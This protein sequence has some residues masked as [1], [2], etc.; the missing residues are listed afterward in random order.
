MTAPAR[1]NAADFCM[2]LA[3]APHDEWPALI[4]GDPRRQR[5]ARQMLAVLAAAPPVTP[6]QRAAVRAVFKGKTS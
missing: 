3:C 2:T 1:F 5:I 6:E 4:A